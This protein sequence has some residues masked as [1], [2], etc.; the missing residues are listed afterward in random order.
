MKTAINIILIVISTLTL[1]YGLYF[2]ITGL[3]GIIKKSKVR[4]KKSSGKNHFAII[5]PARNESAV[6]SNLIESLNNL[7][8][9]KNKYDVYVVPNNC[10]DDT[11]EVAI[12]SGA[13]TIDCNVKTTTKGDVLNFAFDHLKNHKEI[14]AYVIFDADNVVHPDFLSYM[15]D[16]LEKGF[17]VAQG[18]RD[19]KNPSDNGMSGSYTL[20][21]LM[22]NVF[23]NRARMGLRGSA[24]IN[25]TG[26]MVR[27]KIIDDYGFKTYTLTEDVE[28]TGICA[29]RGE[30]IAFVEKAITYDEY[31][32]SFIPSWHQRR[33]WTSGT[34]ECM[35]RYSFKL[36]K[37]FFKTGKLA[38]LDM[39]LTYQAA[40]FQLLGVICSILTF[41][42]IIAG[43]EVTAIEIVKYFLSALLNI[44]IGFIITELIIILY[45]KE[46]VKK[47]WKGILAFPIFMLTWIPISVIC[48][49]IKKTKWD[50]IKH[51]RNVKIN[52]VL[53][54]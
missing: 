4:F 47:V 50:V 49:I 29:L 22:Q 33:R 10:T 54:K 17:N 36:L 25:G 16:A 53:S 1:I 8:Y 42:N 31:P 6:I 32:I 14:D 43:I 34:I 26:F 5:I 20:F 12:K 2:I 35:R 7:N 13:K 28:F 19:A 11:K 30:R 3:L 23:L 15:D 18:L 9:P 38:S 39:S 21:Y 48:F 37:N 24:S 46:S 27:K 52:E 41:V 44:Y 40:V 51:S 45:K